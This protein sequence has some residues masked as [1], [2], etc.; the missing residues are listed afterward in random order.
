MVRCGGVRHPREWSWC[1]YQELAGLRKRFRILDIERLL[2]LMGNPD[3]NTLR[4]QY[5]SSIQERIAK[6][7]LERE[8][9]WTESIA[10]GSRA[11]VEGLERQI[12]GRQV[13]EIQPAGEVWVL[14]EAGRA[15]Q[16]A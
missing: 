8:P 4:Q 3:I 6:G 2:W 11:F 13:L 7:Q 12:K 15:Y 10:V 14:K 9:K 5:E 16:T 1:G